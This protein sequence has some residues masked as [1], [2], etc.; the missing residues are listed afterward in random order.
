MKT[1]AA[2]LLPLALGACS[3]L[4]GGH[5]ETCGEYPAAGGPAVIATL[6]Q[7]L[8]EVVRLRVLRGLDSLGELSRETIDRL[9]D[10]TLGWEQK[11]TVDDLVATI[12][13][14]AG[15]AMADDVRRAVDSVTAHSQRPLAADCAD[16]QRC[17][18]KGAAHG[19]RVALLYAQPKDAPKT[20]DAA[21]PQKP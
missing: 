5:P 19:A 7:E 15:D 18:V 21:P 13:R 8:C 14:D 3:I 1:I 10:R 6:D 16:A 12:R 9:I 2:A 17:L 4:V 11:A 20:G